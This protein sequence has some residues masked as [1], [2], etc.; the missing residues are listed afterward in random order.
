MKSL[1]LRFSIDG[2]RNLGFMWYQ[3]TTPYAR[4]EVMDFLEDVKRAVYPVRRLVRGP[5]VHG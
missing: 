5:T 1:F 3:Q 2:Y 4:L